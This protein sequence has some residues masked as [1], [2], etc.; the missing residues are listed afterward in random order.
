MFAC[1]LFGIDRRVYYRSIKR[2]L[3]KQDKAQLVV[4]MILE[5]RAK[6]PRIG[7]KKLYYLLGKDLKNTK[8]QEEINLLIFL[9]PIIY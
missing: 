2:R 8:K 9:E 3:I 7:A 5:V 6:M 1:T 4:K